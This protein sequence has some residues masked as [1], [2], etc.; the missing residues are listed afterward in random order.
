MENSVP[1]PALLKTCLD[2]LAADYGPQYLDTD[3]LGVAHE[4]SAPEDIEVA[5]FVTSA[6]AYGGASQ[7]RR[8]AH[9]V[10]ARVG[11]S[12][13][14]F[15]EEAARM[16]PK[17]LVSRFEGLKHRWTDAG[18]IAFLFR[19]SG[20]MIRDY[21]GIGALVRNLDDPAEETIEG[22]L[23]RFAA[24]IRTRHTPEFRLGNARKNISSLFP[25]PAD[26]SACKRPAMFFRWMTRGPDGVDF[27]LWKF[28]SPSRLVIPVDRHIARMAALLGLT[29]RTS[30]DWKMALDITR[31][32]R[33]LDPEDPIRYDFALVRPGITGECTPVSRGECG[34]CALDGVCGEA[35][36]E[37]MLRNKKAV[38]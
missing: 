11:A 19:A 7:I 38:S 22:V 6:L 14:Q 16:S 13:A 27:G 37:S 23:T 1:D 31:S 35:K 32:L 4:Y 3:P 10:L 17:T 34:D 15:A 5:G 21:G 30:P 8:S 26:G 20:E 25:S 2:R 29:T 9:D 24:W 12:P 33:A 28:I 36:I 18:D